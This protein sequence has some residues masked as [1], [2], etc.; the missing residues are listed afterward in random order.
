MNLWH[1]FFFSD[2]NYKCNNWKCQPIA[3]RCWRKKQNKHD[4][5]IFTSS[6]DLKWKHY[7]RGKD[8]SVEKSFQPWAW[9]IFHKQPSRG[10]LRRKSVDFEIFIQLFCHF[11]Q[12]PPKSWPVIRNPGHLDWF[13]YTEFNGVNHF[14]FRLEMP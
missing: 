2:P 10:V 14:W 11:A 9:L 7:S 13:Q 5:K 6:I 4:T 12:I 8:L 3:F 1:E